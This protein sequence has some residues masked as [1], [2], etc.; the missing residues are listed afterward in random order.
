MI[1]RSRIVVTSVTHVWTEIQDRYNKFQIKS[2]IV[3]N[4]F[5]V[6]LEQTNPSA[7][8]PAPLFLA[9]IDIPI[10]VYDRNAPD[11]D[12]KKLPP[13]GTIYNQL[14]VDALYQLQLDGDVKDAMMPAHWS[15]PRLFVR[16]ETDSAG[17]LSKDVAIK[18]TER[19]KQLETMLRL[20]LERREK[21][22]R[23]VLVIKFRKLD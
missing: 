10:S 8:T 11:Y 15:Q 6:I 5:R 2:D 23:D 22:M 17:V 7:P 4:D 9:K 3:Y 16:L 12:K 14:L 21:G 19:D 18:G 20:I 1:Q 13:A